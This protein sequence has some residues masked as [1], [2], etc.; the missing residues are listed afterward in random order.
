MDGSGPGASDGASAQSLSL[1]LLL[2]HESSP[3]VLC[4]LLCEVRIK[5]APPHRLLPGF[6]EMIR[7]SVCKQ[8]A[9]RKGGQLEGPHS[10]RGNCAGVRHCQSTVKHPQ[11]TVMWMRSL[12]CKHSS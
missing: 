4:F 8:L 12:Y 11:N 6:N 2:A 10:P 9:H 7:G 5:T 3:E 1:S